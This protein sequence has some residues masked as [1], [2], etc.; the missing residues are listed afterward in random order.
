MQQ[1]E[2]L[3]PIVTQQL[4]P[5]VGLGIIYTDRQ[6]STTDKMDGS[7]CLTVRSEQ[8]IRPKPCR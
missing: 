4:V 2:P 6:R 5:T 7:V 1:W 3:E 8:A